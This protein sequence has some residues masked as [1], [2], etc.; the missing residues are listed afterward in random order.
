PNGDN[1]I[2]TLP[3]TVTPQHGSL[4]L[5]ANGTYTYQPNVDFVG[6]DSFRYEVCDDGI[7]ILCDEATVTITV[8]QIGY[9]KVED[10]EGT[11]I[12]NLD[13]QNDWVAD[14]S[15][16]VVTDPTDNAN[17]V[18]RVTGGAQQG[19]KPVPTA[20]SNTE[21][22]ST[23]HFRMRRDGAADA[24]SGITPVNSPSQFDDFEVQVGGQT[25]TPGV[26]RL[27]DAGAFRSSDQGFGA[28]IWYCMWLV[29][30]NVNAQYKVYAKGGGLSAITQLQAGGRNTF[31]FRNGLG[32]ALDQFFVRSG[33]NHQGNYYIDDI[34]IDARTANLT[35]P[36]NDCVDDRPE[37]RLS[38]EDASALE[39]ESIQ[40]VLTLNRPF[41]QAVTVNFATSDDTA[42]SL[43]DYTASSGSVTFAPFET[44]KAIAIALNDDSQSETTE[45]FLVT[46]ANVTAPV[47]IADD[48]A[49]GIIFDDDLAHLTI[50]DVTVTEGEDAQFSISLTQPSATDVT[51]TIETMNNTAQANEDYAVLA[52]EVVIPT[53]VTEQTISIPTIDDTLVETSETF[54]VR[55]VNPLNAPIADNQGVATILD[56]DEPQISV[57]DVQVI[58]GPTTIARFMVRLD[59]PSPAI[60]TVDYT[61]H[62]GSA[63][64]DLDY[65][66]TEGTLVFGV[67]ESQKTISVPILEDDTAEPNESFTVQLSNAVQAQI[68]DAEGEGIIVDGSVLGVL[69]QDA[70]VNEYDNAAT[71]SVQLNQSSTQEVRVVYQTLNGTALAGQDYVAKT[72]QLTFSPGTQEQL[73]SIDLIDDTAHETTEFFRL[74]IYQAFNATFF[75]GPGIA[76]IIDDDQADLP[77]IMISDSQAVEGGLIT[78]DL[79][80]SEPSSVAINVDFATSDGTAQAGIDY[81]SSTGTAIFAPN[82]VQSVITIG[83]LDDQ[84]NEP[85]ETIFVDLFNP[86]N[87]VLNNNRGLGIIQ[88]DDTLTLSISDVTVDE[89]EATA[90]FVVTLNIP[91]TSEVSVDFATISD[92]ATAPDDFI[93]QSGTLIFASGV[94]QQT[95][96]VPIVNDDL[97]EDTETFFVDLVD[98]VNATLLKTRGVGTI[99]GH[100]E[101]PTACGG[102]QA[103][104]TEQTLYRLYMPLVIGGGAPVEL[105]PAKSVRHELLASSRMSANT[106]D[107]ALFKIEFEAG[108]SDLPAVITIWADTV[109]TIM[110]DDGCAPDE[111]AGDGVYTALV[112]LSEE[113]LAMVEVT[114]DPTARPGAPIDIDKELMIRNLSVIADE[115]RTRDICGPG[116]NPVGNAD[117]A[118]AF[119]SLIMNIAGTNNEATAAT[120]VEN[121]INTWDSTQTIENGQISLPRSAVKQQIL[122]NWQRENGRLDLDFAPFR[123][124]SIVNRLDLRDNPT[125]TSG[126]A[127]ELRFVWGVLHPSTCNDRS[128][129]VIFEY[130]IPAAN[131]NDIKQWAEEIHALGAL[132][133]EAYNSALQTYTN[134]ITGLNAVPEKPNGSAINQIRSNEFLSSPWELREFVLSENGSLMLTTVKQTPPNSFNGST[135]LGNFINANQSTLLRVN[136][137]T[138]A[139]DPRHVVP[140]S[141]LGSESEV[142]S[143]FVWNAPNILNSEA[144]HQFAVT[145]CNGCHRVE[146]N[147]SFTHVSPRGFNSE[148]AISGFLTGVILSDP[149]SGTPRTF[150]DLGR[151]TVDLNH[152]L[153]ATR[154]ELI[155]FEGLKS[156]TH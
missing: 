146:T 127:G 38:I 89:N 45:S 41:D 111:I 119:K 5:N 107:N 24:F 61:T 138:G 130:G 143:S 155:A 96:Q 99:V 29:A 88:D 35:L 129:T 134:K 126:G 103:R 156:R 87:A 63:I 80:L 144:R 71:F 16:T 97:T 49:I 104:S 74:N 152:I 122:D 136:G 52:D 124:L 12:G 137:I 37:P 92:Q 142:P 7:P 125:P 65:V 86:V 32:Q 64:R 141:L 112:T 79:T 8:K 102:A 59:T 91:S 10:F 20:I 19:Y 121:W 67:N 95:I 118:W 113:E 106:T 66:P 105:P 36:A 14:N 135:E 53:G 93:A 123:L 40:F 145:T 72:G 47:I 56:N 23:I 153:N 120:F 117:G 11:T 3:P 69:V 110:H 98:P 46:I 22:A 73:V 48:Q 54:F 17:Q 78:F 84:I 77:T 34:Y 26:F 27:R 133:G 81:V 25:N 109:P 149:V 21:D 151:R 33:T 39:G 114:D 9:E 50:N 18:L 55:L 1:L 132:T 30:D 108:F 147:T 116:N 60:V 13:G 140:D 131:T 62:D 115:T 76:T 68:A 83:G 75:G 42:S 70:T 100:L 4:S 43:T 94:A 90:D 51:V 82:T 139:P 85:D 101:A 148:A 6:Q 57:S 150:N 44:S 154:F 31:D 128:F 15:L 28:D 58:E 2:L